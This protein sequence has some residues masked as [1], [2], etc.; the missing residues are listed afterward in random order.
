MKE[1]HTII[2][3]VIRDSVNLGQF[4]HINRMITLLLSVITLSGFRFNLL[5]ENV[6]GSYLA[7]KIGIDVAFFCSLY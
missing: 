1:R 5:I 2:G 3:R 4:D 6:I 7:M